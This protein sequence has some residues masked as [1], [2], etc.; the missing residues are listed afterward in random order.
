MVQAP[1]EDVRAFLED[2]VQAASLTPDVLSVEVLED[3]E[4]DLVKTTN[5]GLVSSVAYVVLRCYPDEGVV[6]T[7][8]ESEDFTHYG[9]AYAL[10]ET[11]GG[12]QVTY[13]VTVGIDLP[14]PDWTIRIGL[15]RSTAATME[16]LV[17]HF[18]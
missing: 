18:D 15:E 6:E 17:A 16:A 12:T 4:C 3:N 11:E 8:V 9:A 13:S 2:P 7:L 10:E 14:V 1:V 5:A